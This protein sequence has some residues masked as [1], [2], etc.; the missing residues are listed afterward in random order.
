MCDG[1]LDYDLGD[2]R[3]DR[4]IDAKTEVKSYAEV[5]TYT[6]V[7]HHL[8]LSV[9]MRPMRS[10]FSRLQRLSCLLGF[11][12]LTMIICTMVIKTPDDTIFVNQVVIGPFRFSMENFE[13]ALVSV[14]IATIIIWLVVFFFVNAESIN[15]DKFD[16]TFLKIYR[17]INKKLQ[18]DDSVIGKPFVPPAEVVIHHQYHFLPHF[19]VYIGWAILFSTVMTAS[20]L[21]MAFSDAWKNVKSEEWMTTICVAILCSFLITEVIKVYNIHVYIMYHSICSS[22]LGKSSLCIVSDV[23]V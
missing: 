1:W 10:N 2:N 7:E 11:V 8:W 9:F 5:I 13:S 6:A 20:Y 16:S 18:W 17:A 21:L 3:V 15:K 22:F 19:A 14:V 4:V 23:S 12:Y